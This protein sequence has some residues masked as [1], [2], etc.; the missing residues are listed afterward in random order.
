MSDKMTIITN[1]KPRPIIDGWNL[2]PKERAEFDYINWKAIEEGNDS[3]SFFRYKGSLYDLSDG[4]EMPTTLR[5]DHPFREWDGYQ[6][7]SFFSGI[8]I[9]YP[10]D[11]D[12]AESD[13]ESIV[14]GRY[15]S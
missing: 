3:A 6:S 10:R 9:R 12:T 11:P 7:D 1:N 4:F 15:Y 14:V 8:L 13:F 5:D 2:T